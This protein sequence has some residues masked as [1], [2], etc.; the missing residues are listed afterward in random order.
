M[1][2]PHHLVR[3]GLLFIGT[4]LPIFADFHQVFSAQSNGETTQA[5]ARKESARSTPGSRDSNNTPRASS[6]RVR[7]STLKSTKV[8]SKPIGP[9]AAD[10][11]A[12]DT[13]A[14]QATSRPRGTGQKS[15]L[16]PTEWGNDPE[17]IPTESDAEFLKIQKT[18]GT[19]SPLTQDK[20]SEIESEKSPSRVRS[21]VY[22]KSR[23]PQPVILPDQLEGP[24]YDVKYFPTVPV[25][26]GLGMA[27]FPKKPPSPTRTTPP[28][29]A[30]NNP[31]LIRDQILDSLKTKAYRSQVQPPTQK[32]LESAPIVKSK[33]PQPT[34]LV[35]KQQPVKKSQPKSKP[36]L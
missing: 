16:I 11:D 34:K 21:A 2:R 25:N 24:G 26:T 8:V 20:L 13:D 1:K 22:T 31:E 27:T 36:P 17:L 32:E 30:Y 10:P 28:V 35:S 7:A 12:A 4:S 29:P 23:R 18:A 19:R 5:P 6:R 15:I 33:Q 3:L 9:D 14:R